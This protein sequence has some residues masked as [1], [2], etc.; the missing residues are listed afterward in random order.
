MKFIHNNVL[1]KP[2]TSALLSFSLIFSGGA[3]ADSG[4]VDKPLLVIGASYSNGSLP[5]NDELVAP[6]FGIAVGFGSYLNL[7]NALIKDP[8]L[9]GYVINEAQGGA[10]TFDRPGCNPG[11]GC[12]A[13][14]WQGYNKQLQKA[15]ARVTIP[16]TA[17][18]MAKYVVITTANDCM[19]S[20]AFG[21]PQAET[22]PCN[23]DEL[24]AYMDRLLAVGQQAIDA[25]LV[26]IFDLL[27]AYD[28]L[29][30]PLTAAVFGL[31]WIADEA[32]YNTMRN[33]QHSRLTTE[34]AGAVVLD[35]WADFEHMGDGIHPNDKTSRKAAEI[36]AQHIKNN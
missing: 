6:V 18:R 19:H 34:L 13:G 24:N 1:T 5:F 26:P 23:M 2:L 12:E 11:P 36:I 17:I 4:D 14:E 27:P 7:G 35:I 28:K 20:D 29:D 22:L 25:G 30:L 32:Y 3:F 9:P 16:G 21:I 10:T 8:R 31:N 33:L 15:M